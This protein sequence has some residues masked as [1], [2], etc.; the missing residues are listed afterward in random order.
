MRGAEEDWIERGRSKSRNKDKKER[1]INLKDLF[2][3]FGDEEV[4]T[5]V[6]FSR[7]KRINLT[8]IK[9]SLGVR[10]EEEVRSVVT[11]SENS[12]SAKRAK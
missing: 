2:A 6:G 9:Q 10:A 4:E 12:V 7:E 3:P 5:K 8:E 11:P 1:K